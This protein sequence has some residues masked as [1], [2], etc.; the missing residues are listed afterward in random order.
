MYFTTYRIPLLIVILNTIVITWCILSNFYADD[1]LLNVIDIKSAYVGGYQISFTSFTKTSCLQKM[2]SENCQIHLTF[3]SPYTLFTDSILH[4][5]QVA[6]LFHQEFYHALVFNKLF[7]CSSVWSDAA[8]AHLLK[9]QAVQN[10]AARIISNTRKFDNVTPILKDLRRL[11]P[12]KSQLHY[13][14]SVLAF[15]CMSGLTPSYR[16]LLFLKRGEVSGRVTRNFHLLNFT[17]FKSAIEQR[18]FSYRTVLLKSWFRQW[19]QAV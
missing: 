13:R 16:A 8:T 1:E 14:D 2:I 18:T 19:F 17:C 11:L 10:F 6:L 4:F 7:Y 15:K 3:P 5:W 12:V 9:L